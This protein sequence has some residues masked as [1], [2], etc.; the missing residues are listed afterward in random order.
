MTAIGTE[1]KGIIESAVSEIAQTQITNHTN[2]ETVATQ[3]K[4][5]EVLDNE[6]LTKAAYDYAK[7]L[8]DQTT[9]NGTANVTQAAKDAAQE[10]VDVAKA[11]LDALNKD[12]EVLKVSDL[13]GNSADIDSFEV[14]SQLDKDNNLTVTL[15]GK[16]GNDTVVTIAN[17]D[18]LKAGD[19]IILTAKEMVESKQAAVGEE[20]LRLQIGANGGQEMS[21]G[22]NSMRAEDL[23]I[24]QVKDGVEGKAL[25]VTNQA[26]A[27]MA[28]EAYDMAIQKV[29]TERAKMGAV[30]NRLEH[31]IA[32]LDTAA[33]NT[34]NA[35]SR[36]RD[37][38][39]ASE[40]VTFSKTQ[41]LQQ[42]AQSMLAQA[43]QSTQGVLSLLQ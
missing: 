26:S 32:N 10:K 31:T 12:K 2:R 17:A 29:S 11:A 18:K 16:D 20:A 35:E 7:A 39:M 33:E 9:V 40:M 3:E 4:L 36:I 25:D 21:L 34:Q 41:I 1:F 15:K 30:Q 6:E 27:A 22:I 5:L 28:I 24:V 14:A 8:A 43:N 37:V 23:N 13:F 38:D 19:T 42:A